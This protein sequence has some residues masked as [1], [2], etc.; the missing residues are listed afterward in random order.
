[1]TFTPMTLFGMALQLPPNI[2]VR[3]CFLNDAIASI[4]TMHRIWSLQG[5]LPGAHLDMPEVVIAR[6][7][8]A[9]VRLGTEDKPKQHRGTG[10]DFI[11]DKY[12]EVNF[13]F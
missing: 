13:M 11:Q 10:W 6:A 8:A 12:L 3:L 7:I 9:S 5:L 2:F 1:M 4:R